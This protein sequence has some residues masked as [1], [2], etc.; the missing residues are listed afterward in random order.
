MWLFRSVR[1]TFIAALTTIAIISMIPVRAQETVHPTELTGLIVTKV[2]RTVVEG[3][4]GIEV[5]F[6]KASAERL[7]AFTS[8]GV[9]RS[10]EFVVD[11]KKLVTLRLIDPLTDGN[12]LLTGHIDNAGLISSGATVT[13]KLE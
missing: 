3:Q 1:L 11:Q 9:G 8:G 7:R 6:D 10:L 13:V 2:E 5:T 4:D 12:V